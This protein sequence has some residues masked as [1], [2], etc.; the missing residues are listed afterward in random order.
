MWISEGSGGVEADSN[1]AIVFWY[2]DIRNAGD[3]CWNYGREREEGERRGKDE[4][5]EE[6][7]KKSEKREKE[8]KEERRNSNKKMEKGKRRVRTRKKGR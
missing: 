1:S 3:H 6:G 5:R 2:F 4:G 7:E 8:R